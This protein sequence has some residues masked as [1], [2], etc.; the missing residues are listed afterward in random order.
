MDVVAASTDNRGALMK[1]EH[2][3]D[4]D[5]LVLRCRDAQARKYIAE[6]VSCYRAGAFRSCIV[7][8]WIAVVFDLIGKL[9]ELELTG[10]PNARSK[11]ND[12]EKYRQNSDVKSA[13]SFE[14]KSLDLAKDEFQLLSP[15]QYGDLRRLL[16]DRNRCA[17]PSMISAD[18]AYDP[19]AELARAHLRNAVEHLLQHQ[20]VQ[21]QAAL[22]RL[23][24]E[25]E[26]PYFPKTRQDAIR[27]FQNGPLARPRES[28]VRNFAICAVKSLVEADSSIDVPQR[29]A[30]A[31]NAL[32]SMH[33]DMTER[34]L[35]D[36]LSDIVRTRGDDLLGER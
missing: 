7:S 30:A 26:S 28:L 16:E 12:L 34:T 10:D 4:L 20:P 27:H 2:L 24:R 22:D 15:M 9:R 25:V 19:P 6:A 18:D 1:W 31:L 5:E 36:K 23:V 21:G 17:H 33:R 35:S 32:L 11:L 29:W 14:T 8:V 13:L 3:A